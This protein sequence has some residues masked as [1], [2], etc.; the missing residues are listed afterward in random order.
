VIEGMSFFYKDSENFLEIGV[1][2][3]QENASKAKILRVK[4]S[5]STDKKFVPKIGM[6]FTSR[7]PKGY[8]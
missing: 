4:N 3:L 2:E 8:Y 5:E 1:E 7:I 6:R